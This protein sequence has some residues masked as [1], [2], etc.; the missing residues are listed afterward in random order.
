MQL[1]RIATRTHATAKRYYLFF[2][3][4]TP[5]KMENAERRKRGAP[6]KSRLERRIKGQYWISIDKA[7]KE[8]FAKE[9]NY[10]HPPADQFENIKEWERRCISFYLDIYWQMEKE[11]FARVEAEN[12]HRAKQ[13]NPA[14]DETEEE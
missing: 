8:A 2:T 12:L 4:K 13:Y 7:Q 6:K 14:N 11:Y 10:P 1:H 5:L 3:H 9:A